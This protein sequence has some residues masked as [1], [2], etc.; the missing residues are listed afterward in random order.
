MYSFGE[1][2]M[3]ARVTG[4]LLLHLFWCGIATGQNVIYVGANSS[5]LEDGKSWS[6]SFNYLQDALSVAV[7]GDEVW[8][9]NEIYR[10]DQGTGHIVG[11]HTESFVISEPIRILEGYAAD[12]Q[13]PEGRDLESSSTI[14]SGDLEGNDYLGT[15]ESRTDNSQLM[16][17]M[18]L[19]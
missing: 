10:P 18:I 16:I 1:T 12:E 5:G 6:M 9:G 19:L 17:I 3:S 8:T 7:S 11:S 2:N 15:P 13:S 4:V 14:V